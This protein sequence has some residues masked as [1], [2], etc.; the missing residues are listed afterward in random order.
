MEGPGQRPAARPTLRARACHA[1]QDGYPWRSEARDLDQLR[2]LLHR[3]LRR[4]RPVGLATAPRSRPATR[5][6]SGDR[7]VSHLCVGLARA[8]EAAGQGQ[9]Y[10]G[11]ARAEAGRTH[12]GCEPGVHRT[13]EPRRTS[14]SSRGPGTAGVGRGPQ[15]RAG[16]RRHPAVRARRVLVVRAASSIRH[17]QRICAHHHSRLPDHA[18]T[19]QSPDPD[20]R[21]SRRP[22]VQD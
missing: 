10:G 22:T 13:A 14:G 7:V 2:Q 15:R 4:A 20:L 16:R 6:S 12:E 11:D 9:L 3:S 1:R 19:A 5:G 21:A 8:G 17:L 18:E